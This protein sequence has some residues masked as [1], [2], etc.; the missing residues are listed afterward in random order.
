MCAH[1][2][3]HSADTKESRAVV[4]ARKKQLASASKS[5]S[6]LTSDK[7]SLESTIAQLKEAAAAASEVIVKCLVAP[8]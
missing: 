7:E 2:N 8:S 4:K 1:R 5:H 3:K 6:S